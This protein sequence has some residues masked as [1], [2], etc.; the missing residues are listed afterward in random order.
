MSVLLAEVGW[1]SSSAASSSAGTISEYDALSA[2]GLATNGSAGN[3][4]CE[5]G[6]G[7][8]VTEGGSEEGGCEE[9]ARDESDGARDERGDSTEGEGVPK[10]VRGGVASE[11]CITDIEDE[12]IGF[13]ARFLRLGRLE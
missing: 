5:R 8:A 11:L 7:D 12:E 13:F 9:G 6:R 3:P 2:R 1:T 10:S 4:A